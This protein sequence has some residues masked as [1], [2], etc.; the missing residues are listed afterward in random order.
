MGLL[1][2]AMAVHDDSVHTNAIGDYVSIRDSKYGTKVRKK[3][4]YTKFFTNLNSL[5]GM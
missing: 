4:D 3:I 2:H 5:Y 1:S